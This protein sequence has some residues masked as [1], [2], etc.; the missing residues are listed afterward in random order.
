MK[1]MT[2]R[3][4]CTRSVSSAR[5]TGACLLPIQLLLTDAG[6]SRSL[7]KGNNIAPGYQAMMTSG[8]QLSA[9]SRD[10]IPMDSD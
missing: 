3:G 9:L 6:S 4:L 8:E 1:K 10:H 2:P 5:G 7:A